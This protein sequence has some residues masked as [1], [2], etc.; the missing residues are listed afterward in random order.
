MLLL[1]DIAIATTCA[2]MLPYVWEAPPDGVL[3][4]NGEVVLVAPTGA[5]NPRHVGFAPVVDEP[6]SH[7]IPATVEHRSDDSF[8]VVPD[9]PL[10][11]GV[12]YQLDIPFSTW[13]LLDTFQLG[14]VVDSTP[15][16]RLVL[17]VERSRGVTDWWDPG[18][19][20]LLSFQAD[21]SEA[22]IEV[23]LTEGNGTVH[24]FSSANPSFSYGTMA[25]M[26]RTTAYAIDAEL[27]VRVRSIDWAGNTSA[28][29][30]VEITEDVVPADEDEDEDTVDV[31]TARGCSTAGGPSGVAG[32]FLAGL[33]LLRRRQG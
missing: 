13:P 14:S 6:G 18:V 25:C 3:P 33:V 32:W 2:P 11:P 23:E 4:A 5:T 20:D 21:D 16:E 15:P 31:G 7:P 10:E 8:A 22:R 24:R 28:W 1:V 27:S 29:Q 26:Q 19:Y 17:T 9:E 30:D 12:A